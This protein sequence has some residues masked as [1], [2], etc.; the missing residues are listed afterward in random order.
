MENCCYLY[1]KLMLVIY[2]PIRRG[3]AI[4]LVGTVTLLRVRLNEAYCEE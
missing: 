3:E 1:G 4:K 2:G